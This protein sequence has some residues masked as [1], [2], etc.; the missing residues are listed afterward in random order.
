MTSLFSSTAPPDWMLEARRTRRALK[1]RRFRWTRRLAILA[2]VVCVASIA[3]TYLPST[4]TVSLR[5]GNL[6]PATTATTT[7]IPSCSVV[8]LG[9]H[10][11]VV[12]H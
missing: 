12:G 4:Y 6:G 7:T 9:C 5:G 3:S 1:R 8:R 2:L 11:V 10:T